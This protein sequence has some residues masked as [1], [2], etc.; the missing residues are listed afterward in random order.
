MQGLKE[1]ISEHASVNVSYIEIK[2]ILF[3]LYLALVLFGRGLLFVLASEEEVEASTWYQALAE[4]A[5]LRVWG[6]APFI[7]SFFIFFS[8][9][10]KSYKGY[11][12]F[13]IGNSIAFLVYMA[14]SLT[15]VEN[16]LNWFTPYMNIL[17]AGF[18]LVL[19]MLGVHRL[20]MIKRIL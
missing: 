5:D 4:L 8:M 20:W 14:F 17:N 2:A 3:K 18:H 12:S 19:T 11:V 6:L 13:V 16:G 15:G 7:A 10:T 1:F 9:F